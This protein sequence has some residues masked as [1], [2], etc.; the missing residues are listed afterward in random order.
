M[1]GKTGRN[2]LFLSESVGFGP[3]A[4]PGGGELFAIEFLSKLADH[5]WRITIVCPKQSPL[6]RD[7]GL[8]KFVDF[9]PLNLSVKIKD[10]SFF[11]IL[12]SWITL[13]RR[14]PGYIF[15]GN[16]YATM[17][18][19]VT[20]RVLWG[21][22]V[23]CHLHES[24]YECYRSLTARILAPFVHRFFAISDSV[25]DLF[26]SGAHVR[27]DKVIRVHNGVPLGTHKSEDSSADC[28]L[29]RRELGVSLSTKLV[30]MV[31]RTNELKGHEVLLRAVN[32]VRTIEPNTTFLIV[33]LEAQT[34]EET[35]LYN[36]LQNVIDEEGIRGCV[37]HTAFRTDAR[38]LMHCA[39]VMVVP[40][41]QEGFGRTAIEAMA[42]LTPVIASSTGGLKEIITDGI[43]GRLF[44]PGNYRALADQLIAILQDSSEARRLAQNAYRT[45]QDNFSTE[46]MTELIE[47]S[48]IEE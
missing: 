41:T 35:A 38:R 47:N 27:S 44:P 1:A 33:G 25:R 30:I 29:A 46:H 45:V 10:A 7:A 36:H 19:L 37:K 20:A 6:L 24:S 16:G 43:N 26:I 32:S 12:L 28:A 31:A 2:L 13:S 18:W 5:G 11:S 3:K 4:S 40:S 48:L 15:Y 39:D 17:K 22:R 14:F 23:F 8:Q 34:P 9:Q 21:R 42:E